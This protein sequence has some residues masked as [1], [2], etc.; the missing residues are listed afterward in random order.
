MNRYGLP[1]RKLKSI[2]KRILPLFLYQLILRFYR[3]SFDQLLVSLE[4]D[5][6]LP[7]EF[8]YSDYVSN[9]PDLH[10][11]N[12]PDARIHFESHGRVEGRSGNS[13]LNRSDFASLAGHL[14]GLILEIGPFYS[15]LIRGENSRFADVLDK[16]SLMKRAEEV[17]GDPKSVPR[18]DWLIDSGQLVDPPYEFTNCISSH[19]LEHQPNIVSHLQQVY[20]LLPNGGRYFLLIPDRRYCFD[21]LIPNSS[22]GEMIAAYLE[23]RTR[24]PLRSIIEHR[25]LASHNDPYK[26]WE[27]LHGND[28]VSIESLNQAI[29][30]FESAENGYIDV[31]SW[32]FDPDSFRHSITLLNKLN[33]VSF[34]IERLYSTRRHSNEFWAILRK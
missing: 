13:L 18:I 25:V 15:P 5:G 23:N 26:H 29:M 28:N 10:D 31:H 8:V 7:L 11:M 17:G 14:G 6:S 24:H 1:M 12:E 22:P 19:V 34:E 30:E 32:Y 20:E 33:L 9:Y 2:V 16:N 27:N 3:R 4:T 21:H